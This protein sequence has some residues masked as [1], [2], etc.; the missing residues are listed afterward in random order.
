MLNGLLLYARLCIREMVGREGNG[1]FGVF[2]NS[3]KIIGVNIGMKMKAKIV[4]YNMMEKVI[5]KVKC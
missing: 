2:T 3:S 5:E 4:L 1:M